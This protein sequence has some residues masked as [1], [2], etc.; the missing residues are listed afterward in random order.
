MKKNLI[1]A[2][3][4]LCMSVT[5]LTTLSIASDSSTLAKAEKR[6]VLRVGFASFVPWAMQNKAGEFVGFEIDVA[7]R[8]AK[9]L[10]LRLQLV[11]TAWAG[12][13]PA[14]LA[15]KFDIIIGGMGITPKRSEQ[16]SFTEPY[17]FTEMELLS[18]K[19]KSAKLR[20]LEDF[21]NEKVTIIVRTGAT[22]ALLVK[23]LLPKANIRQ[24]ADEAPC[25]EEVLSGRA[26]A[27]LTTAP[28]GSFS[29]ADNPQKLFL[30]FAIESYKEPIG[31]AVKK[32]DK[33]TLKVLNEW[34]KKRHADGWLKDR[35]AYWFKGKDWAKNQ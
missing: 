14:L 23:E 22:A 27:F 7:T 18:N 26:H 24:F 31:M 11:P 1:F 19:E 28:L 9:D 21:N 12:I 10:G 29:V 4:M 3:F 35:E 5:V 33:D 2:L 16:V 34:I 17:D 30:P 8:L 15:G 6:G 13:I 32:G 20:T 25:V